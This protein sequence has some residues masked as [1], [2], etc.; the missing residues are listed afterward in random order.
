[1]SDDR[2]ELPEYF[3]N[4]GE[5]I[6]TKKPVIIKTV[7]GSCVGVTIY[8]R[9]NAWA[10]MVH[11]LLPVSPDKTVSTK[12]GDVAVS[13]LINKFLNNGSERRNMEATVSGGSFIIFDEMEV[14]FIGDRNIEVATNIL[15]KND[16][17][18]R[19]TNTGGEKGRKVIFNTLHNDVKVSLLEKMKIDDL[20][21][22][23]NRNEF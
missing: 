12:Y 22:R 21:D 16:I 8:D 23:R 17:R 20:Y 18:I 10:G 15:K 13:T 1:M 9:V 3:I 5:L 2:L 11:F 14:F 6:F 7:L 4:P 19:F